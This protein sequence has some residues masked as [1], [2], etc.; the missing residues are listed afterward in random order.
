VCLF[1]EDWEPERHLSSEFKAVS[2]LL[3]FAIMVCASDGAA[4]AELELISGQLSRLKRNERTRLGAR[5]EVLLDSPPAARSLRGAVS[6]L[7]EQQKRSIAQFLL[8]ITAADG[9]ITQTEIETL[10]K[11]YRVLDLSLESVH[12]DIH[13]LM[14]GVSGATGKKP[15]AVRKAQRHASSYKLP[16]EPD[17]GVLVL[18]LESIRRKRQESKSVVAMLEEVFAEDDL[19]EPVEVSSPDEE[20]QIESILDE[21]HMRLLLELLHSEEIPGAR[22]TEMCREVGLLPGAAI[23]AINEAVLDAFDDVLIVSSDPIGVEPET[24]KL[25]RGVV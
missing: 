2:A 19:H 5:R 8:L 11:A 23:E 9:R 7:G 18:D 4:E 15:V 14:T 10:E 12:S 13:K 24:A 16:P 3:P 22:W 21:S 1:R 25:L 6:G 17:H 20:Q